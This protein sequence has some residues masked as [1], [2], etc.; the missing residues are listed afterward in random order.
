[1][2]LTPNARKKFNAQVRESLRACTCVGDVYD[3]F[4]ALPANTPRQ[5]ELASLCFYDLDND[6]HGTPHHG[7]LRTVRNTFGLMDVLYTRW[8]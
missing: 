7:W 5:R 3:T 8:Q 2:N 4:L 1:M 6:Y